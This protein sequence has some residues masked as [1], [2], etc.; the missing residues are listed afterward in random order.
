MKPIKINQEM[1]NNSNNSNNSR[2]ALLM[3]PIMTSR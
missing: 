2:V 1:S 3:M